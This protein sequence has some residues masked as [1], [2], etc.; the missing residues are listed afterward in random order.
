MSDL[1][2]KERCSGRYPALWRFVYS[3]EV[4]ERQFDA[5]TGDNENT[6]RTLTIE[7][8][9]DVVALG[10]GLAIEAFKIDYPASVY[11]LRSGPTFVCYVDAIVH[12]AKGYGGHFS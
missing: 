2:S 11:A 12:F 9:Y 3:H 4:N 10:E 1:Q 8:Q 5:G 7:G 6:G